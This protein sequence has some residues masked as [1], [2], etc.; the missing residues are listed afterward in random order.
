[1]KKISFFLLSLIVIF[2]LNGCASTY[3]NKYKDSKMAFK[4]DVDEPQIKERK[5]QFYLID[6]KVT[7]LPFIDN[8][9][10]DKALFATDIPVSILF[11]KTLYKN[12]SENLIFKKTELAKEEHFLNK[13]I[14]FDESNFSN[15]KTILKTDA[16]TWG[17]IYE[18]DIIISEDSESQKYILTLHARG[19]IKIMEGNGTITYYHDFNKIRSYSFKTDSPFSY[20]IYDI[21]SLGPFINNFCEWIVDGEI[22]HFIANSE[23][24]IN[25]ALAIENIMPDILTY[26]QE[27]TKLYDASIIISA[28][29]QKSFINMFGMLTGAAAGF[30]T[31][32]YI[33]G[34]ETNNPGA[35]LS[36]ILIGMPPGTLAGFFITNYFADRMYEENEKKAIFYAGS[37]NYKNDFTFYMSIIN[38]KL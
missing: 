13:Y 2:L 12:L 5:Q 15:L 1:M 10:F 34:G 23:K 7:V 8:R 22:N 4:I 35:A 29:T 28:S 24:F 21:K 19:D 18:F 27:N 31:A 17:I 38:L 36:G 37:N 32:Y 14:T 26:P 9:N 33:A 3:T 11:S 20:T 25:G 6:K 16:V 30:F